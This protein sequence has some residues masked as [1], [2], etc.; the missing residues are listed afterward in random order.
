MLTTN[1][2]AVNAAIETGARKGLDRAAII[3]HRAARQ[4]T[5]VDTGRLRSS[6]TFSTPNVQARTQYKGDDGRMTTF[7]PPPPP[8]GELSLTIGTNV[9]YAA[10]V[11]EGVH[12]LETVKEHTIKSHQRRITQAF[13][14]PLNTPKT[15]TVR[16]Y[17]VKQH[18]RR[19]D[20]AGR[21]FIETP[22]REKR[23]EMTNAIR[24]EIARATN[25]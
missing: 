2:P 22:G 23:E 17:T 11:H 3:W 6:V 4:A 7:T 15:I 9:A 18:Q 21:K 10:A 19:V 5:P 14:R 8:P 12:G 1:L 13:G 20:R 16:T 25:E 24:E